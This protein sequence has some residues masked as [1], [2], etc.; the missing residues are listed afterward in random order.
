MRGAGPRSAGRET[1]AQ[2]GAP[3]QGQALSR[4]QPWPIPQTAAPCDPTPRSPFPASGRRATHRQACPRR[5]SRSPT[6]RFLRSPGAR[7][8][9][10]EPSCPC[11]A[12]VFPCARGRQPSRTRAVNQCHVTLRARAIQNPFST[13]SGTGK[14]RVFDP[15][16]EIVGVGLPSFT[17]PNEVAVGYHLVAVYHCTR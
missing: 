9:A 15:T 10:R 12:G 13:R 11:G 1:A 7:V 4:G 17:M 8:Q 5:E 6:P 3:L 16:L 2:P 14:P